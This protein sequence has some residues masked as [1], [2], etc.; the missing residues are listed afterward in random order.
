[1][2]KNRVDVEEAGHYLSKEDSRP[3]SDNFQFICCQPQTSRTVMALDLCLHLMIIW[4]SVKS[5]SSLVSLLLSC[6]L[7]GVNAHARDL[8]CIYGLM[9]VGYALLCIQGLLMSSTQS[10]LVLSAVYFGQAYYAYDFMKSGMWGQ[11]MLFA[12]LV[13]TAFG[14]SNLTAFFAV[15]IKER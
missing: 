13:Y 12:V 3:K 8:M 10:C 14:V 9:H 1:M 2:A 15:P 4:F 5:P 7:E 6:G 11:N